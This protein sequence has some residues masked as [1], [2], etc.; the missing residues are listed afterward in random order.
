MKQ[1]GLKQ[2]IVLKKMLPKKELSHKRYYVNGK[3]WSQGYINNLLKQA[4]HKVEEVYEK[5][6]CLETEWKG[7]KIKQKLHGAIV[8]AIDE[9]DFL[10]LY[11]ILNKDGFA[12]GECNY[13][14][15]LPK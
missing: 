15:N 10:K 3:K 8:E 4:G 1:I 9:K 14:T 11:E 12:L 13:L 2:T 7:V 6:W 5:T